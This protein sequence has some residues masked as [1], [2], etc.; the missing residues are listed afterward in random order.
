M[1]V[2][3]GGG[4]FNKEIDSS[5]CSHNYEL[6]LLRIRG[7]AERRRSCCW[8]AT[9][10]L[11]Y[12]WKRSIDDLPVTHWMGIPRIR[13][14]RKLS[15]IINVFESVERSSFIVIGAAIV[16]TSKRSLSWKTAVVSLRRV[17][18]VRVN[19][20]LPREP[21]TIFTW[22]TELIDRLEQGAGV[23]VW[24]EIN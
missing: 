5:L 24:H 12:K 7:A 15:G 10:Y 8:P 19:T 14:F 4:L 9:Q 18:V 3:V 13:L 11:D 6:L 22:I 16:N 2:P 20:I 17:V 23:V 1:F 21:Y